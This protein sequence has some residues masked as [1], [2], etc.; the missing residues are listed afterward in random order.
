MVNVAQD[1]ASSQPVSAVLAVDVLAKLV[2]DLG[3]YVKLKQQSLKQ[4]SLTIFYEKILS[5]RL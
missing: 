1:G 3:A 2:H 5:Y 4:L